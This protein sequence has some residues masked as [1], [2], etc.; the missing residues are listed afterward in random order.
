MVMLEHVYEHEGLDDRHIQ[1]K[2]MV[3]QL[4]EFAF[5]EQDIEFIAEIKED[6][7]TAQAIFSKAML[8]VFKKSTIL[9]QML[10]TKED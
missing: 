5:K 7:S 8:R 9:G 4:E 10:G 2:A 6:F 1:Y 3:E